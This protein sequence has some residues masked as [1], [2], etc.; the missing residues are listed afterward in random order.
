MLNQLPAISA[1]HP[2]HILKTFFPLLGYYGDLKS[3]KNFFSLASDVCEWVNV[4]PVPWEDL[5]F[6]PD[7]I[8]ARCKTNTLIELFVRIYEMKAL[9]DQAQYWCC[10]SMESVHY[11]KEIEETGLL[12][13]YL[14]I[15]RD[16]RDVALSFLKAI[17][18]PKHVYH[19]AKKWEDEQRL[20]LY[21]KEKIDPKRFIMVQYEALIHDPETVMKSLCQALD[22]PYS[23]EVFEYFHSHESFN[24]ASS[25]AMWKNVVNPIMPDNHNKFER[26]LTSTQLDI[27][28]A[29]AGEMLGKLGYGTA[30]GSHR[31]ATR[32]TDHE[33]QQFEAE[34]AALM[35]RILEMAGPEELRR[36][37]PQAE[38]L[39]RIKSRG[40]AFK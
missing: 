12:P 32:Y 37:I 40:L 4:N 28:E 29:V 21:W 11:V 39:S 18:G 24:T 7:E 8:V 33:V 13:Y 25:G 36:R 34:G 3:T 5:V 19:L 1:P 30:K 2:P 15:Y 20:S 27:F 6:N 10:K 14:Y 35:K 23:R 17:V 16:G 22:V 38:L 31:S 26:E 9:H